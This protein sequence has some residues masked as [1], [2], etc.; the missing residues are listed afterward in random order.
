MNKFFKQKKAKLLVVI[1]T[2]MLILGIASIVN[3]T[4]LPEV[5]DGAITLTED[6][7]LDEDVTAKIVVPSGKTVTLDLNGH[8]ITAISKQVAITN[9]GNLTIKGEGNVIADS[10]YAVLNH[11]ELLTIKGGN[12]SKTD[13]SA[14]QS[15]ISNG[16]YT[17]SDN[18]SG[19]MSQMIINGGIFDG[20]AYTAVKND[21][22]G[23]MT[24]N[25]GTF[26][27]T[28]STAGIQETG[29]GITIN[30][31]TFDAVVYVQNYT[32]VD[33]VSKEAHFNGGTFNK[34]VKCEAGNTSSP[35]ASN[36]K[37]FIEEKAEFN[38]NLSISNSSA[39]TGTIPF[40]VEKFDVKNIGGSLTF[41]GKNADCKLPALNLD[42]LTTGGALILNYVEK[43]TISNTTVK[44]AD[45]KAGD[46]VLKN[47]NAKMFTNN[48]KNAVATFGEG[49]KI[50][51]IKETLNSGNSIV[52][53]GATIDSIVNT[54]KTKMYGFESITIKNGNVG[55]I[56][57]SKG[58]IEITGGK[59]EKITIVDKFV[60]ANPVNVTVSDGAF[61][62]VIDNQREG[63]DNATVET[64]INLPENSTIS[65]EGKVLINISSTTVS[66]VEEKYTYTGENI[67][68]ELTIKYENEKLEKDTD[69]TVEYKDNKE[70]GKATIVIT[71]KGKYTGTK[72]VQFNI[73][74]ATYDMSNVKFEDLTVAYDGKSH[75]ITATGLPNGVKVE[76][77]NNEKIEMGE[78]TVTAVFTGDAEHYN[79]IA[80]MTAT[81]KIIGKDI[82]NFIV[83]KIDNQVF[84]GKG[85][86][87]SVEI[88]DGKIVLKNGTD[89]TLS[90]SN[91]INTGKATVTIT[92]KGDYSGTKTATFN[93]IPTVVKSLK[94]KSQSDKKITLK[95][96]KNDGEVTGYRIYM[97]DS[98]TKK[99]KYVGKT[100]DTKYTIKNLKKNKKYKF[101]VRAY[102]KI[103]GTQYFGS[104]KKIT[105][106]TGP[107]TPV[108]KRITTY[109]RQVALKWS[110]V[111]KAIGYRIYRSTD[112]KSYS[113]LK[114]LNEKDATDYLRWG[115]TKGKIYYFKIRAY[116]KVAGKKIFSSY[117][118]VKYIKVK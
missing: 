62:D 109:K 64:N 4:G 51:T 20:G 84:T 33:G 14:T 12:Y 24:I 72:E 89:Y 45:I 116:I 17:N 59:V 31:G 6:V 32:S 15:L 52:I 111:K 105:A 95:W 88:K 5:Q 117:S 85:I 34:A 49:T 25:G 43:S 110:K 65:E 40:A 101:K 38:N 11:G 75:L 102:K 100:K 41:A 29:N 94:V 35:Q 1:L 2:I 9:E 107:S 18:T 16:W 66:D 81:L 48:T 3:A 82:S 69:Y 68:P 8:T 19:A 55:T 28:N 108:L 27:S 53:D 30:G 91:N 114:T 57:T 47:V 71:G 61:V 44:G 37:V 46:V 103:D 26:T 23:V 76:Y 96:A 70:I 13:S 106:Y 118:N 54:G 104:Y 92:G 67:A 112:G 90:Y 80:D 50:T 22:F 74:K 83:S 58:D 99:Y 56:D 60:T 77:K 73:E 21:S 98:K 113:K 36:V 10:N 79:D 39:K 115:L 78:Y 7:T 63:D 93:I 97:Y 87:P 86:K 42:G